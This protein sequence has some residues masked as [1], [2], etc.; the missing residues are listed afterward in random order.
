MERL[1]E[2][3]AGLDV[4]RDTVVASVRRVI[5]GQECVETRTFGTYPDDLRELG[6][7]LKDGKVAVAGIES[8]G[9]YFK[10]VDHELRRAGL[11]VW[12]VNASHAKQVPG[13]KTDVSDSSW[14][15]KL[16]MHGL[17]R[18]SFIPD[19]T[20]EGLRTLTRLR[21][22]VVSEGTRAKNRIIK[23]LEATGVK[24]AG[25][26]SDVLGKT[27]RGILRALIN[28]QQTPAQMAGLA[29]GALRAKR[30]LLERALTV[31]L[32][33]DTRWLLTD[34]VDH[35]ETVEKRIERLD[36]RIA[37]TLQTYAQD[38]E[39]LAQIP[40]LSNVSIAA[41]LA[42]SGTDMSIF[43]SAKHLT[44][45]AGLAPGS[46]ESAGKTK[47]TRA[48][49]GNPW[50]RTILVQIA[51]VVSRT[52]RS[53]WRP[54][55]ARLTRT[56]GSAKKAALAVARKLLLAIYHVLKSRC[57]QPFSPPPPSESQRKR[58]LQSALAT[59]TELGFHTVLTPLSPHVESTA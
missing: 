30:D 46:N 55:F 5:R 18:P 15:S 4:H 20:L 16:V 25:I 11:T 3:A 13:R 45:W 2:C 31:P 28:G 26:C 39:L 1:I 33:V 19:E 24:L 12:V 21:R 35:F 43:A 52:K 59:L 9:V 23:L 32:T 54:T 56:T 47:S 44:S 57:Y 6:R 50:L 7:W 17:V 38:V 10:P 36:A 37:Q 49:R 40:G 22:Q 53:P 41:V 8:T 42:E 29:I 14:L 34:L 48:R 58:R 51:W 27:G